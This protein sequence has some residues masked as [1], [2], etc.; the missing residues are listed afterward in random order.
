MFSCFLVDILSP[1]PPG[2]SDLCR[3]I[4][5]FSRFFDNVWAIRPLKLKLVDL[6][7]HCNG[8]AESIFSGALVQ[9]CSPDS[10]R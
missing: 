7:P 8:R 2:F 1:V 6:S 9:A 4:N 3:K 10:E 5:S